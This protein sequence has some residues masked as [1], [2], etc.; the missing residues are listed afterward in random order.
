MMMTS[1]INFSSLSFVT[2]M[3]MPVSAISNQPP[4]LSFS[5]YAR[6][7]RRYSVLD[8]EADKV[9]SFA[10]LARLQVSK[11]IYALR[12]LFYRLT[13]YTYEIVGVVVFVFVVVVFAIYVSLHGGEMTRN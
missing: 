6:C 4:R 3:V 8:A 7:M 10:A 12:Q 11:V 13:I 2:F 9:S 5:I 1:Q